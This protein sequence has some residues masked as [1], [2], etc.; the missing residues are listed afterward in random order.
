MICATKRMSTSPLSITLEQETIKRMDNARG[1]VK[2]STLIESILSEFLDKSEG[3]NPSVKVPKV[4]PK[5]AK[6]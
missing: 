4:S 1:L 3:E 6:R 5:G 2:R